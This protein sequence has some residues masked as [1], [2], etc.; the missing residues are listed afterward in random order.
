MYV[1]Y[2]VEPIKTGCG[3]GN[4]QSETY[5]NG[6]KYVVSVYCNDD[7]LHDLFEMWY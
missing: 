5:L 3:N 1:R 6:L 7:A 2:E 4:Y